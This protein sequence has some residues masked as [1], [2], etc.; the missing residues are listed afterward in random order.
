MKKQIL[1]SALIAMAGVGL[2]AS[3][4]MALTVNPPASG[5]FALQTIVNSAVYDGTADSPIQAIDVQED[6]SDVTAWTLGELN[7]DAYL[8]SLFTAG[9][10]KLGIA[11]ATAPLDPTKQHTFNLG[12]SSTPGTSVGFWINEDDLYME[13]F[14]TITKILEPTKMLDDIGTSFT[15]Y[16]E[17]SNGKK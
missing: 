1:K 9:S 5:E 4:A 8:I 11:S 14:N 17:L 7:A 15:F 2:L 13:T 6:Q 12:T 10:G 16:Y 3:G